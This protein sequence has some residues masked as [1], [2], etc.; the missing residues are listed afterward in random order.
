MTPQEAR[1]YAAALCN[2]AD[3]AEAEGRNLQQSDLADFSRLVDAA[4]ADLD[5]AVR[6]DSEKG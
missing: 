1:D 5:S 2:A 3:K 6:P 4:I